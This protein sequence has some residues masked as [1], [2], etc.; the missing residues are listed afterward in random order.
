M[1]EFGFVAYPID[2][3]AFAMLP[4]TL[5]DAFNDA[6]NARFTTTKS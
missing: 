5:F 4:R 1:L 6:G 2:V 3:P